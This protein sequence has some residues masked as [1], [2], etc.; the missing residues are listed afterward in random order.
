MVPHVIRIQHDLTEILVIVAFQNGQVVRKSVL[1][2][3]STGFGRTNVKNEMGIAVDDGHGVGFGKGVDRSGGRGRRKVALGIVVAYERI[4]PSTRE[5]DDEQEDAALE[6][7]TGRATLLFIGV[8]VL[9]SRGRRDQGNSRLFNRIFTSIKDC[10]ATKM[11]AHGC[12]C[13]D[14][15]QI[16]LGSIS[17]SSTCCFAPFEHMHSKRCTAAVKFRI[18]PP[19]SRDSNKGGTGFSVRRQFCRLR[20]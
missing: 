9:G 11:I 14:T 10:S 12:F 6:K 17:E 7:G 20:I 4:D 2:S 1:E 18:P 3:R 15:D 13:L 5:C 8:R 19:I 16:P